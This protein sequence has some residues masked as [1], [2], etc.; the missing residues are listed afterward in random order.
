MTAIAAPMPIGAYFITMPVNL[1]IISASPSQKPS[2]TSLGLP[3][4]CESATAKRI[5]QKTICST[6]LLAAASKKLCGH[7]V[8]EESGERSASSAPA[9]A[10]RSADAV[11]RTPTPGRV[12]LTAARPMNS[13]SVVTISK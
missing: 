6:S 7:D 12:R 10:P 3:R 1:N 4:T 11:S 2:M 9:P 13:A 8:L 5:D